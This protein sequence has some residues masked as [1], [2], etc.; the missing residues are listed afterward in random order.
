MLVW[1]LQH[2]CLIQLD[3]FITSDVESSGAKE[4]II[5]RRRSSSM[6]NSTITSLTTKGS[7]GTSKKPQQSVLEAMGESKTPIDS[8]SPTVQRILSVAHKKV[9]AEPSSFALF[10][11]L[12][13]YFNGRHPL[14]EIVWKEDVSR[15]QLLAL[16]ATF[17]AVLCTTQHE[18]TTS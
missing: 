15:G 9:H 13:P 7:T 1:L 6:N 11:R 16:I 18:I 14:D 4:T 3:T 10:A 8:Y 2:D 5:T 12:L 17:D